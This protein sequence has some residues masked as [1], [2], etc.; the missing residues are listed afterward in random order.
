LATVQRYRTAVGHLLDF[1]KTRR[2]SIRA[3]RFSLEIAEKF[4]RHLRTTRVSP[5][6]R[7][8]EI[9]VSR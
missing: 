9:Q 3:D 7:A 2:D 8:I 1:V 5:H 6:G 4:V